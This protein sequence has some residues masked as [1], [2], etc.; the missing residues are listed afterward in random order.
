VNAFHF[1][2]SGH[3]AHRRRVDL[4]SR[5]SSLRLMAS[6]VVLIKSLKDLGWLALA[7]NSLGETRFPTQN[8]RVALQAEHVREHR[9]RPPT[10]GGDA[11]GV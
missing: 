10:F 7:R 3:G 8:V 9:D 2:R 11:R 5:A 4:Y 6:G 1:E